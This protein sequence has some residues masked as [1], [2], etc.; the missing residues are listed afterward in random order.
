MK[1]WEFKRL[2]S[3]GNI[4]TGKTPSSE[5]PEDF[6]HSYPFITP[7]DIPSTQKTIKVERFLSEM[8]KDKLS[9]ILLPSKSTCVVCI[10]ATIGKTCM[11]NALSITNQQ[12]NSI[13]PN[14]DFSKDFVYYLATTLKNSLV[15]FAGGAATPIINKSSFS[16]I[17][18]LTPPLPIQRKIA[19]VLSAYDDLIENNN[20]RIAIL[21]KMAGELYR[22]WFVRL[23]FP[24][25]EK[26]KV[27]KGVPEGWEVKKIGDVVDR[28]RFGKIYREAD[29]QQEG[30]IIVID[31]ST[32][33]YLGFYN[34]APEHHAS[35]DNPI[36]L[37]G[38]HSCKMLLML[39]PFSLAENVIPFS[40][41]G[42]MPTPFLFYMIHNS[43]E[44][45]EYKRHWTELISK[46]IYVPKES[47]QETFSNVVIDNMVQKKIYTDSNRKIKQTRDRL[48]S[49]LMS[50]KIDLEELDIQFPASMREGP[51]AELAEA[52]KSMKEK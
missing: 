19:A 36:I 10:G 5:Y 13:I 27:V 9:S 17:K 14:N 26:T 46:E 21:E 42:K 47:L 52:P 16:S 31:Q 33:E 29:L 51:V 40:A 30:N 15:A 43:I 24:G 25:H 44:T 45:T 18:V 34:G 23:R 22:E 32:N 39:E 49:H 11:S 3:I 41:K 20:R 48:L 2:D 6:G 12:I 4:I 7:S 38:D 50:G 1:G 35:R 28:K 37:F 8:G